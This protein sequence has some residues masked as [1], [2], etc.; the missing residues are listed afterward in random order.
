MAASL[1]EMVEAYAKASKGRLDRA[2][3]LALDAG[4]EFKAVVGAMGDKGVRVA[5]ACIAAG[6]VDR[7]CITESGKQRLQD[8]ADA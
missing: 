5:F 2:L 4:Y 6:W 8:G 3:L 1:S 7:G